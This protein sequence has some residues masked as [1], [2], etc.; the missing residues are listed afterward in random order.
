MPVPV[1]GTAADGV[2]VSVRFAGQTATTT[3]VNGAWK[4]WLKPM[5]A[6]AMP[7][8]L[9]IL[10]DTPCA[11]ENV[12][13]GDVWV[14]AGQSNMERQ[15][16]PRPPQPEIIGWKEAAAHADFP[17]IRQ[18]YVPE[19]L[20][21]SPV[22]DAGGSWTV[23]SPR[24]APD[25]SA[26]GFF[27]ARAISRVEKVPVGIVFSARGG[28]A[29]EAWTSAASL[30][31]MADFRRQVERMDGLTG[32][33][34]HDK[35]YPTVLYNAMVA[36]LLPF[37]ITGVIWY[38]GE[39]NCDRGLQYREL[40]PLLIADWR[41]GWGLGDFPFLFVQ[42]APSKYWTPEIREAQL[43][44]LPLSRN[45]A[46]IGTADIGDANDMHPAQKAPVG[47]RLALAARA[48]AYGEAIEYSGPLFEAMKV[49]GDRAVI[50]FTHTRGGLFAMG[51][52][53]RGFVVAGPDG[54]RVPAKA[55]IKGNTVVV[56]SESVKS[57]AAVRYGWDRAPDINLFNGAGLPASPFRTDVEGP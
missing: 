15:L 57:P 16:G 31:T 27:F 20:S 49:E 56:W 42:I 51:G 13:V 55:E 46:M 17:E 3:A 5:S 22:G 25:F 9:F 10:G 2:T 21:V 26:V 36:P 18:F 8:T 47:E 50:S 48:L 43:L 7:R 54:R 24:T 29:A 52:K 14:A 34:D 44:T 40:F 6:S 39:S 23:C 37:P 11:I 35:N 53:L 45:T 12:L 33:P 1:W 19:H 32:D 28:T 30:R 4:V 38:Q 41:R